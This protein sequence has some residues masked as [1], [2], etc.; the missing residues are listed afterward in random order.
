MTTRARS[1]WSRL[2]A[3][4]LLGALALSFAPRTAMAQSRSHCPPPVSGSVLTTAM[5]ADCGHAGDPA[6]ASLPGCAAPVPA[7]T[8]AA[9]AAPISVDVAGAWTPAPVDPTGRPRT[10]PP[11]PPPN[12]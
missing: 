1:P 6:C 7:L 8:A 4:T 10:G 3:L 5:P 9:V 2:A 11:T 12:S